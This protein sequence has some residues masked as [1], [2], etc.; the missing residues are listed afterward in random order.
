MGLIGGILQPIYVGRPNVLMSPMTFLQKPFRW[1]SAISRFRATTSGGPNFAYEHCI[2]KVTP[3]Q[4]KQLDLSS[5]KLAFNGA[6]PV[7][8]ETLRRF[9]ETFAPCGFRAEAFYPCF[10]LAEAT[11][12]VSGGY[13][14]E[15]PIIRSFDAEA[16]TQ[17]R[18]REVGGGGPTARDL[19]GCGETL[20]DQKIVIAD[21]K[22]ETHL[23]ARRDRRDLGQ[24]S[25]AWPRATGN[26][27]TSPRPR[28]TPTCT[29]R[30]EGP[31]LRTGDLG[32]M[33]DG[34]LFITGRLK[35]LII[36]RGVNY[37][38]QDIEL[39][40]LR[41]HP[42]LRADCGAAFAMEQG[43]REQLVLVFEVERHKQGAVRRSFPG[44]PPRGGRR[45]RF[46]RR[47]H[48]AD[49]CRHA[50]R[51]PP[52]AKSSGTPAARAIS[53]ARSTWW[54]NGSLASRRAA[55]RDPGRIDRGGAA[56]RW[57]GRFRRHVRS[58]TSL[59]AMR[60]AIACPGAEARAGS[61]RH[62]SGDGE[63]AV[64]GREATNGR[65]R[66]PGRRARKWKRPTSSSKRSAA[67][68]RSGPRA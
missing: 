45:T 50:C 66:L 54:A 11:L 14:A 51:K 21:P 15:P 68:P 4:R 33:L 61:P 1:L 28:S 59:P 47:C 10:G 40:V 13:V 34:E 5:W 24:R 29:I 23:P 60:R 2:D 56:T 6:E 31:F 52:A 48:R 57:S 35:D 38:P 3:E 18:A 58:R 9:A 39:T 22:T 8:A 26:E 67:W 32:F 49:P 41:C 16:L 65:A 12:I 36:L 19:V 44:H 30:G 53:T 55:R 46:D 63:P 25:R 43:G 42:R 62:E 64:K 20:P 37:Y 27:P 7:R 17:G